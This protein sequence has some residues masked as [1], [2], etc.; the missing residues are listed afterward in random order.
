MTRWA[1]RWAHLQLYI[2]HHVCMHA[3][4]CG[5]LGRYT[6]TI[7]YIIRDI[8]DAIIILRLHTS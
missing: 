6:H 7:Y 8:H 2:L 3:P 4:E 5:K 1:R